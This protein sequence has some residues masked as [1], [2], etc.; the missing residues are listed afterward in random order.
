MTK[1]EID[2]FLREAPSQEEDFNEP[3]YR[4]LWQ[5]ID[6]LGT[7][8]HGAG[9]FASDGLPLFLAR[10]LRRELKNRNHKAWIEVE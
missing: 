4:V 8:T 3:A 10:M 6:V 2:R 9:P 1:E 7:P 5:Q